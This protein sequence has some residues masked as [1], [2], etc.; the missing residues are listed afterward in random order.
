[1]FKTKPLIETYKSTVNLL[2]KYATK[3]DLKTFTQ[4]KQHYG[5]LFP[6]K[7]L[8][9]KQKSPACMYIANEKAANEIDEHLSPFFKAS[10]CDTI[11]ELNPGIGAFTRKLLDK[12]EKFK[13]II[14]M[15]PMDYFMNNFQEM[16]TLYPDRVKVKH[17]DL[18][19]IWKLVYQD[20]ID[21]GSR[22]QDLLVDIP[23]KQHHEGKYIVNC[24]KTLSHF[25]F[26]FRS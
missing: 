14:L 24:N 19:N 20:K 16:H 25:R 15:E 9:K 4:K 17:G 2:R 18:V 12:E 6:D 8:N 5:D 7:L 13:K 11:L 22:V 10:Q 26:I 21:N 3:S 1:M 23:T